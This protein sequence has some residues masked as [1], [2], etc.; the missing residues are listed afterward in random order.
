[1]VWKSGVTLSA[2]L[3]FTQLGEKFDYFDPNAQQTILNLIPVDTIFGPPPANNITIIWD[4][5]SIEYIGERTVV[6][7]NKYRFLDIPLT[8][9][10]EIE[11]EKFILNINAGVM[12]NLLFTQ[13]GK[14]LSPDE[15]VVYLQ[16]GMENSYDAYRTNAGFSLIGSLGMAYKLEPDIHLLL[17]PHV[18]YNI[19]SLDNGANP[20]EHRMA[21]TGLRFGIRKIL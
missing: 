7:H 9:G 5:L 3:S 12:I 1:M 19:K 4:T 21:L 11:S 10:Y 17:E 13:R 18:R 16:D 15:D 6:Q 8:V 20:V 14:I 2:G